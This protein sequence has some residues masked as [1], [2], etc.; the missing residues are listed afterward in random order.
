MCVHVCMLVVP[1]L[2]LPEFASL[3]PATDPATATAAACHCLCCCPRVLNSPVPLTRWPH[4]SRHHTDMP[5]PAMCAHHTDMPTPAM[6]AHACAC[7]C[8][9]PCM[10]SCQDMSSCRQAV[11]YPDSGVCC[12]KSRDCLLPIQYMTTV[13]DPL[14]VSSNDSSITL[15]PRRQPEPGGQS[16]PKS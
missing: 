15:M 1:L 11:Y 10:C 8:A 13:S 2:L 9:L 5:T 6:C 14:C 16:N 4:P 3:Q 7:V 12:L